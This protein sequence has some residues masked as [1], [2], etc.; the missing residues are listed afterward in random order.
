MSVTMRALLGLTAAMISVAIFHQGTSALLNASGVPT[1][2]PYSLRPVPPFGVPMLVNRF[3]WGGLYG[4][5][6]GL[7][8]PW[9]P[10]ASLWL[11][12][13]CFGL[14]SVLVGWFVVA[15]LKGLP[16]AGGFVPARMWPAVVINGAWGI[17]IGLVLSLLM[18]VARRTDEHGKAAT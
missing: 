10:R 3:F 11:L 7:S 14:L 13:F 9:L 4:L 18:R 6:F 8:L 2:G 15:P 17:G 16:I 5:V 12:G 1:V